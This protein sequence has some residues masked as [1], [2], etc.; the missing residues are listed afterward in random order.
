MKKYCF[1]LLAVVFSY[2]FVF[3]QQRQKPKVLV[4]S[5][6]NGFHHNSIPTGIAA[7]QQLGR[8]NGFE[9]D[10]TTDSLCFNNKTLKQ[11]AAIIFLNTTGTIFGKEQKRALQQY[12]QKGGG[13]VGIHA[14]ADTEYGWP[15]FNK[16]IG[17]WFLSHP[18]QQVAKLLVLQNNHLSTRHLAAIWER[19]DEWYN[20]R[21]LNPAVQVL[22]AIDEKSYEGGKNGEHHPMAWY[23]NFE[24]GRVFYTALGHTNEA[25]SEPLFL[26]HLVGGIQY[27]MG[28]K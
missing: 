13:I 28:V 2:C 19:K 20:F 18:K 5:K 17:A 6:T 27:A 26:Q 3:A 24:G 7:I 15:W 23:H 22:I 1:T 25:Y 4:I 14:A 9:V 12:V 10:S 16:M 21:D 8:D 11:Y